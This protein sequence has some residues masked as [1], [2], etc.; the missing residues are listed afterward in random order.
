[1]GVLWR[2]LGSTKLGNCSRG[3]E[4]GPGCFCL[5]R[6]W[7]EPRSDGGGEPTAAAREVEEEGLIPYR[8]R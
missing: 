8:F 6:S 4:D 7:E 1:V 3:G 5:S 2:V